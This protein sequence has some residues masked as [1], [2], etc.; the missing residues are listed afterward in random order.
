MDNVKLIVISGPSGVGK[1]TLLKRLF[2]SYSEKIGFSVSYTSRNP[3]NNEVDGVDYHFVTSDVF[4]SMISKNLFVEWAFVHG[5]YYGTAKDEVSKVIDNGKYCILDIDVQGAM[6]VKE[7]GVIAKYIFI[8][9]E[10]I[11]VLFK[12]LSS[13]GTETSESIQKRLKNA[14]KELT[15]KEKYDYIIINDTLDVAYKKLVSCIF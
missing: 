9:P 15:Y 6:L 13:R 12:R 1:S 3:R 10:S 7:S 11:D 8:A 14:E 2:A 4:S 5:N